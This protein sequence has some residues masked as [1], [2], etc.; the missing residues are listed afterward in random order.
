MIIGG[1]SQQYQ[2]DSMSWIDMQVPYDFYRVPLVGMALGNN[3]LD[4][5]TGS[6]DESKVQFGSTIIDSGTTLLVMAK[7]VCATIDE[8]VSH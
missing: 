8:S 3:S 2:T 1:Y 4:S 6:Y 7:R 5:I